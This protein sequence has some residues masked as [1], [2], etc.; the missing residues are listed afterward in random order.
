MKWI[1]LPLLIVSSL[2]AI[3]LHERS[4]AE[5]LAALRH[6]EP[7]R[8]EAILHELKRRLPFMNEKERRAF[9]EARQNRKGRN[10]R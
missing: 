9:E 4:T 6:A 5:L 2:A 10:G 7:L 3:E 1:G 8:A